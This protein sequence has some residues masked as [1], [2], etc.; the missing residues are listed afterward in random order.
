MSEE[1][2]QII[3]AMQEAVD[4]EM[5]RKATLGYYAVVS[6][7]YGE[8]KIVLAEDLVRKRRVEK[9]VGNFACI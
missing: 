5:E 6:D 2:K 3:S 4:A 9:D 1:M 8:P 7:E